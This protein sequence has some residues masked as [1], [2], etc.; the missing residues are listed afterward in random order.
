[1]LQLEKK[2][3]NSMASIF[4]IFFSA[5]AGYTLL[6]EQSKLMRTGFIKHK[7]HLLGNSYFL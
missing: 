7:E 4:Y 1:M 2:K 6:L 5:I 3:R